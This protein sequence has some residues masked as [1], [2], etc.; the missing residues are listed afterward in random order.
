MPRRV[1]HFE[2]PYDDADRASAFYR[3]VFDWGLETWP[4][5]GGYVL[6]STG[7]NGDRGPTEPGFINGGLLERSPDHTAPNVVIDVDDIDAALEAVE[8]AGGTRLEERAPV[9]DMGWAAYFTDT[10]GNVVGLW[11][12]K[13]S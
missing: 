1:V 12:T 5:A 10:E 7:P 9:G 4:D 6:A 13:T 3:D 2:L 8:A 11:Q